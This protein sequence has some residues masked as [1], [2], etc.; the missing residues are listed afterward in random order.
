MVRL[1]KRCRHPTGR[2]ADKCTGDDVTEE[3]VVGADEAYGYGYEY[4]Q[5]DRSQFR[6]EHPQH[7]DHRAGDGR[8][9]GWKRFV[10]SSAVKQIEPVGAVANERRIILNPGV[11]PRSSENKFELIF[12]RLGHDEAD[13]ANKRGGVNFR[14]SPAGQ[15]PEAK[16]NE[17]DDGQW[18]EW[19]GN[20]S[21]P[22]ECIMM[23]KLHMDEP[24]NRLI[25]PL[26]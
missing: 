3:M 7:G 1:P 4:E 22:R 19:I 26:I 13:A 25:K 21:Q 2:D 11:R 18:D 24:S 10:S 9:S 14:Q 16:A 20:V 5:I 8:M 12:G 15:A 17:R 6:I 23:G